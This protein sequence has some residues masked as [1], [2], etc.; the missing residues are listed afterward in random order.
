MKNESLKKGEILRGR[1]TFD[2]IF[3]RGNK[4]KGKVITIFVLPAEQN[5]M[6]VAV[7]KRFKRAVDRNTIRRRIREIYRKNKRWFQSVYYRRS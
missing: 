3:K 2:D 5:Q 7:S 6:G 4:Y 1:G